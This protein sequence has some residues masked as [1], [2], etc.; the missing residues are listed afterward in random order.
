MEKSQEN[1]AL[2]VLIVVFVFSLAGILNTW[3]P[4]A[5]SITGHATEQ[6]AAS[7]VVIQSYFSIAMSDNLSNGINFQT[8]DVLP[9]YNI[10][11]TGN[12]NTSEGGGSIGV[13]NQTEYYITNSW[14]SNVAIDLC[15]RADDNLTTLGGAEILLQNYTWSDST[16][17]DVDNPAWA[18]SSNITLYY[19]K[20]SENIA[21]NNS[22]Y[23]RFW[24]N[25]TAGVSAGTYTN[26]LYFEGVQT[27]NECS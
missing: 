14:D 12:Y 26:N 23:Y 20:G 16:S 24:L 18:D 4:E 21:R 10:N 3:L 13:G 8:V 1:L 17:N 6:S 15:I 5:V 27:G 11:A 7:E 19:V 9:K 22:N 2:T 25:V